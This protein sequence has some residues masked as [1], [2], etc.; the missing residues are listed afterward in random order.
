MTLPSSGRSIRRP[1]G[2]EVVVPLRDAVD[3][4]S[5]GGVLL[6]RHGLDRDVDGGGKRRRERP[7]FAPEGKHG[8]LAD[9]VLD[10]TV[11]DDPA[12]DAPLLQQA[13]R[14]EAAFAVE[15]VEPIAGDERLRF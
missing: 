5:V 4:D 7:V 6:L 9:S 8:V 14:A 10:V 15:E 12:D 13:R 3:T 11:T 2:D 1:W